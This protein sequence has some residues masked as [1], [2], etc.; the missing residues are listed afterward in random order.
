MRP[1]LPLNLR[2]TQHLYIKLVN[3]GCFLQRLGISLI[4]KMLP[5]NLLKLPIYMRVE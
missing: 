2:I 1:V 5:R 4:G 3:Q